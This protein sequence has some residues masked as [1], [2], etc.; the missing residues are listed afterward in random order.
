MLLKQI[1]ANSRNITQMWGKGEK[2]IL[3]GQFISGKPHTEGKINQ[4]HFLRRSRV[5]T[6]IP[7]F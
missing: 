3:N 6:E 4:L 7:H 5:N 2:G 1:H